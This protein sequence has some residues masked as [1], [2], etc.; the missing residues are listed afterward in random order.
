MNLL[1]LFDNVPDQ[2]TPRP[3]HK[4]HRF[5]PV[6]FNEDTGAAVFACKCGVTRNRQARFLCKTED[7]MNKGNIKREDTGERRPN[8]KPDGTAGKM[9]AVWRAK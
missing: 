8:R 9:A 2:P 3:H 6:S 1:P 5:R 7:E 4:K